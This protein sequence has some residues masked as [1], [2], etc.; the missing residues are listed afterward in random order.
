MRQAAGHTGDV[1]IVFTA[2]KRSA[3]RKSFEVGGEKRRRDGGARR[4]QA[5]RVLLRTVYFFSSTACRLQGP[6]LLRVGEKVGHLL[7]LASAKYRHIVRTNLRIAF[8]REKGPVWIERTLREFYRHQG[9][10]FLEFAQ[11]PSLPL[12]EFE[13]RVTFHHSKH[14]FAALER[15]GALALAAHSGNWE[16]CLAAMARRA[17]VAAIFRELSHPVFNEV[18]IRMRARQK[19]ECIIRT[20]G[21][22]QAYHEALGAGKLV[23]TAVDQNTH[24]RPLFIRFFGRLTSAACGW[25]DLAEKCRAP[26]F[27]AFSYREGTRHFAL[28]H[29]PVE[30]DLSG[31]RVARL[32]HYVQLIHDRFERYIRQ[33][34]SQYFWFHQRWKT[35]PPGYADPYRAPS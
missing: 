5:A 12:D 15:G 18:M 23:I 29:P 28:F 21:L 2:K 27:S 3:Q 4:E 33:Y 16:M 6:A 11:E 31:D 34:P 13:R 24:H 25:V 8:G 32:T 35:L 14:L 17:P 30:V 9:M 22:R 20:R 26:F 1:N 7:F 19:M 10:T